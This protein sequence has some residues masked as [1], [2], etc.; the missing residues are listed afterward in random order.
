MQPVIPR[1]TTPTNRSRWGSPGPFADDLRPEQESILPLRPCA[2]GARGVPQ[3][4]AGSCQVHWGGRIPLGAV[5]ETG[6]RRML[7]AGG[8]PRPAIRLGLLAPSCSDGGEPAPSWQTASNGT[9][10]GRGGVWCRLRGRMAQKRGQERN[11]RTAGGGTLGKVRRKAAPIQ[12]QRSPGLAGRAR[13]PRTRVGATG[14]E[15]P[16]RASGNAFGVRRS[17][18]STGGSGGRPDAVRGLEA[19]PPFPVVADAASR[20]TGR[21]MPRITRGPPRGRPAIPAP[22][23]EGVVARR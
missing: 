13:A 19:P 7:R 15:V 9:A 18:T 11:V 23:P 10:G 4:R 22:R 16:P 3:I 6:A 14:P 8:S 12:E 20:G 2:L 5:P 17:I 1:S 21:A